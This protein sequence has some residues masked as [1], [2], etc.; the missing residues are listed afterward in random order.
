MLEQTDLIEA[1]RR[2]LLMEFGKEAI[3]ILSS[4]KDHDKAMALI[5][6]LRRI[7]FIGYEETQQEKARAQAE[8]I[9]RLGQLTYRVVLKPGGGTLEIGDK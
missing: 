8:E 9:V 1:E 4:A 6:Y 5:E 2:N 3:H 7:Y